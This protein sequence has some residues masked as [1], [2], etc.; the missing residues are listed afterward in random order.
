MAERV[1]RICDVT[2][3]TKGVV[4]VRVYIVQDGADVSDAKPFLAADLSPKAVK[5]L[6]NLVKRGMSAP[7]KSTEP[8]TAESQ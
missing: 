6:E 7:V 4:R 3:Q 8:E 5:R 2:G 1:T